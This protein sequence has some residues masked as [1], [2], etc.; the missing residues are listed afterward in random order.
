M[1]VAWRLG[2]TYS[3]VLQARQASC[4]GGSD[5]LESI[6]V[7]LKSLQNRALGTE[8]LHVNGGRSHRVSGVVGIKWLSHWQFLACP[9][10]VVV[11]VVGYGKDGRG[12]QVSLENS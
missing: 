4:A 11:V 2:P 1:Y 10:V 12:L 3:V 7:P 6:P 9:M 8:A 5:S